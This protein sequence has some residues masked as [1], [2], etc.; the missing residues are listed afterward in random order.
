MSGIHLLP[1][2]EKPSKKPYYIIGSLVLLL[3]VTNGLFFKNNIHIQGENEEAFAIIETEKSSLQADYDTTI[4][5][6][7]YPKFSFGQQPN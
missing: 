4:V 6:F 2:E 7:D 1:E 5:H 3:L